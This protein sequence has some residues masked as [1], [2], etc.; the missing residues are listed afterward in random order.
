MFHCVHQHQAHPEGL[1]TDIELQ[2]HISQ[3]L[4]NTSSHMSTETLA[5]GYYY[6]IEGVY[7]INTLLNNSHNHVMRV[8]SRN[9]YIWKF[10]WCDTS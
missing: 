9:T 3:W 1:R 10:I 2:I 6:Y 4:Q 7:N 5:M 8:L